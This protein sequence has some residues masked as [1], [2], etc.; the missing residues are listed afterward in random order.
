MKSNLW[1]TQGILQIINDKYAGISAMY[2]NLEDGYSDIIT[3]IDGNAPC[4]M[5]QNGTLERW[6][7][8]MGTQRD[9]ANPDEMW[10]SGFY[11]LP[12]GRNHPWIANLS[13]PKP[14]SST[15]ENSSKI[16]S[17]IFPNPV[18][19]RVSVE[20]TIPQDAEKKIDY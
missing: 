11:T 14:F 16:T 15:A 7:D 8:Y 5:N 3:V 10:V 19:D 20:F 2:Y 6:G 1:E 13:K 17:N 9:F 18:A 4:T 12:N